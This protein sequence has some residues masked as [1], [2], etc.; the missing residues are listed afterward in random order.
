MKVKCV[1]YF[2]FGTQL[3]TKFTCYRKKNMHCTLAK[4]VLKLFLTVVQ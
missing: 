4:M 1:I 3:L 2:V